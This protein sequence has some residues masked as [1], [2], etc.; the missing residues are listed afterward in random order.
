MNSRVF[1]IPRPGHAIP[2]T[3][4]SGSRWYYTVKLETGGTV[5]IRKTFIHLGD[6]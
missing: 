4:I 6:A 5:N 1:W 3:I 2:V